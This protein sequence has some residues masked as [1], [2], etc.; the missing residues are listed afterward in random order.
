[1]PH[2]WNKVGTGTYETGDRQFQA[3]RR[4]DDG[5]WMLLQRNDDVIGNWE[6]CQTYNLLRDAK[7]GAKWIAENS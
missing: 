2:E 3:Q 4:E 5:F 7:A 6:W 1:M